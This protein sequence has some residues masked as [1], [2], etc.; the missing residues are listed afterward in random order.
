MNKFVK[1][2]IKSLNG[3]KNDAIIYSKNTYS[4]F[5]KPVVKTISKKISKIDFKGI[6]KENLAAAK[7][8]M[9]EARSLAKKSQKLVSAGSDKF[10][11]LSIVKFKKARK[12]INKRAPLAKAALLGFAATNFV[13]AEKYVNKAYPRV[14]KFVKANYPTVQNW[15]AKQLPKV[16]AFLAG[17][18]SAR[19]Q[20]FAA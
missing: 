18:L 9:S 12:F 19:L 7:A 5:A 13:I 20:K 10:I 2:S 4:D 11:K 6:Y 8:A 1:K 15:V 17:Q 14:E 16:E 3:I